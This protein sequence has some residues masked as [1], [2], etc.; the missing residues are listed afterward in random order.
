M[1][2]RSPTTTRLAIQATALD[3]FLRQGY[4]ITTLEQIATRLGITRPA[5]L[6][7]PP[8]GGAAAQPRRAGPRGRRRG[9]GTVPGCRLVMRGA[10]GR[11]AA[12]APDGVAGAPG[13]P[14]LS[15]S[16]FANEHALLASASAPPP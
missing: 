3:L 7:L 13:R 10:P 8:Q 11:G 1:S 14:W 2:R 6:P 15:M 5:G 12:R 16:R 4:D 9:P